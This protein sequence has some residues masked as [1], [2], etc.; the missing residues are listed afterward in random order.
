MLCGSTPGEGCSFLSFHLALFLAEAHNL[1][2]VYVDTGIDI[3]EH[4]SFIA[5]MRNRPGLTSFFTGKKPLA[6]LA[7]P[8]GYTNLFVLPSGA[9]DGGTTIHKHILHG[10]LL[11]QLVGFCRNNFD[12]AIFDGQPVA[13]RPM[14]IE[15]AKRVDRVILVCRY[16]SSRREVSMLSIDKLRNNGIPVTGVILNDRQFPVPPGLYNILK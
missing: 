15:F 1:K 6:A 11:E 12:I 2:T 14:T 9:G 10:D 7:V 16:G 5:D 13:S 3:P 4:R 8:T